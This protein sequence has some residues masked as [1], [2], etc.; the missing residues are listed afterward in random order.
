MRKIIYEEDN[1][2]LD[3]GYLFGRG[4]F[5]TILIK[6]NPIFLK[7]HIERLNKGI[8]YLK[9]GDKIEEKFVLEKIKYYNIKNKAL[10]IIVSEKNI[11]FQSRDLTYKEDDY[12][13]GFSIKLSNIVRNSNSD[14]VKIKS[15]NYLENIMERE[16]ALEEGYNEVLF[17]NE[18]GFL[19][20]G[21]ISNIFIVKN[22]RIY[23]P[24]E[25]CGLL[26]GTVRDYLVKNYDIK[27]KEITIKDLENCDEM[28]ITNSLIGVMG[29]NK[30][31]DRILTENKI[32]IM[33]REEYE[34]KIS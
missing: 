14:L 27:E 21:S 34:A 13:K 2:K 9:L 3:S 22:K 4:V 19:A 32:T 6:E 30:F 26:R 5:E 17:L 24:S 10:K 1:I 16:K 25:N 29:I 8:K 7:E 31:Q 11:I 12:K 23:T 15:I 33:I 28:F 18:K 20:E